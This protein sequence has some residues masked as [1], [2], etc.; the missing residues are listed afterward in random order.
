MKKRYKL[1]TLHSNSN[2]FPQITQCK[3]DGV[4]RFNENFMILN[5][6]IL[7]GRTSYHGVSYLGV[8]NNLLQKIFALS[9]FRFHQLLLIETFISQKSLFILV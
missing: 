5:F 1:E 3:E 9:K 2:K 7:N 6:W 4:F 8:F